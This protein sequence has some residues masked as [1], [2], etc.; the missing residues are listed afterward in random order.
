MCDVNKEHIAIL[1]K[2]LISVY[3]EPINSYRMRTFAR[4]QRFKRILGLRVPTV[5][6]GLRQQI[7]FIIPAV[8]RTVINRERSRQF[9]SLI[10]MRRL[11]SLSHMVLLFHKI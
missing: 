6:L 11:L 4:S 2:H 9:D 3:V 8:G 5:I 7:K 1:G 10:P